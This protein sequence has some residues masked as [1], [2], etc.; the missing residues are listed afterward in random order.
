MALPLPIELTC[1]LAS[2]GAGRYAAIGNRVTIES[3]NEWS[4]RPIVSNELT[5]T[6]VMSSPGQHHG[7]GSHVS[8]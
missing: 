4:G 7:G 1:K 2:R 6:A 8:A 3:L 5:A